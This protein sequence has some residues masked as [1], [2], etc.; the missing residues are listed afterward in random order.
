MT[1]K[2]ADPMSDAEYLEHKGTQCP[3][4]EGTMLQGGP[5]N[6][7]AGTASQEIFCNDCG[8]AWADTYT[9]TGRTDNY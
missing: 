5:V 9:L 3:Y 4:C 2:R 7:D 6:I 8:S 1:I